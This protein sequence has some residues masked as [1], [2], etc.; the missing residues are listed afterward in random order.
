MNK[1]VNILNRFQEVEIEADLSSLSDDVKAALPF[2]RNA[3]D[4]ITDIFL[5]QQDEML[6]ENTVQ[7]V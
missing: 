3:M 6:P 7:L 2:I 4:I 5:R 1:I